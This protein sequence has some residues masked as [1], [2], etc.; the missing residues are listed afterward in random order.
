MT[1]TLRLT[2]GTY[3]LADL[4]DDSYVIDGMEAEDVTFIGP[5]VVAFVRNV[6]MAELSWD[7]GP[8]GPESLLWEVE[9]N[10]SAVAGAIGLRNSSLLRCSFK[11]VGIAAKAPEMAAIVSHLRIG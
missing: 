10:R 7:F 2:G 1:K 4:V 3:R 8:G 11:G 6:T 5:A 9:D